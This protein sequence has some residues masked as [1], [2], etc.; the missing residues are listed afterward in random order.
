MAR[1]VNGTGDA[2]RFPN[3]EIVHVFF[4]AEKKIQRNRRRA[5]RAEKIPI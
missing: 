4:E 1:L 5:G 3:R 2:W